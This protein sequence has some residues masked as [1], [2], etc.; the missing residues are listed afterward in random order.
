MVGRLTWLPA[1]TIAAR[2]ARDVAAGVSF[3]RQNNL[4]LAVKGTGHSY[5]GT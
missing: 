4:R 5:L 3:A 1:H 2:N